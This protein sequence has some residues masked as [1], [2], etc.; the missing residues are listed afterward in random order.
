M[1]DLTICG[2]SIYEI[3]WYFLIYSFLGWVLEV[4]YNAAVSG[5]VVNRGFLN[6]PV[7]PI[8]GFGMVM[9]IALL[10]VLFPEGAENVHGGVLFGFGLVLASSVELF[11]GWALDKLFHARWWDYSD[12]PFNI[13]GYIC[14]EFSLYW[15]L[16]AVIMIRM[17][18]PFIASHTVEVWPERY[19]WPAAAVFAAIYMA[20]LIV[21]VMVVNGLNKDLAE[22]DAL[23]ASMRVVSDKLS[24]ALG[25]ES[26]KTAQ[27]ME[28]GRVKAALARESFEEHAGE[29]RGR[30]SEKRA[31]LEA[32]RTAALEEKKAELEE[33]KAA[34]L[35]KEQA[36]Y[37]KVLSGHFFGARRLLEAFPDM[38]MPQH[39]DLLEEIRSKL[40]KSSRQA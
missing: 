6:G 14:P 37:E 38:K 23:R 26:I 32:K 29:L 34:I 31:I 12:K 33:K 11:G 4:I 18:H 39:K 2:L 40:R 35:R 24:D 16:G 5:E 20:D 15:G 13:N 27:H 36:L 22:L 9:L 3:V 25:T 19:G 8:Y 17:M 1:T 21:T 7:C 30:L 28:E 10:N